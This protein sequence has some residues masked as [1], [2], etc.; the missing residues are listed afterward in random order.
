MGELA[1]SLTEPVT[2][3]IPHLGSGPKQKTASAEVSF[4]VRHFILVIF[5]DILEEVVRLT[6]PWKI[7]VKHANATRLQQCLTQHHC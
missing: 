6:T 2:H 4:L 7:R 5:Q 3:I 1:S